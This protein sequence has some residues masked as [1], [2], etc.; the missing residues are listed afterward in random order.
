MDLGKALK[1]L[2]FTPEVDFVLQ[3]DGD[4]STVGVGTSNY[5][6]A[7]IREWKSSSAQ[8]SA[9]VIVGAY[10][11]W[12]TDYNSKVYQRS[13]VGIGTTSEIIYSPIK[14][15][16]DQLYHDMEDGKL[17]AAATTGSWYVG[18]SSVKSAHPKS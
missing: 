14:T 1:Q 5:G 18:I 7:Y 13:R 15:Q 17:G 9:S 4:T 6:G 16:L 8:P 11:T 2:G 12:N 10:N 3:N